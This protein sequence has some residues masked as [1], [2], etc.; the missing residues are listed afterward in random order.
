MFQEDQEGAGNEP[1]TH[2]GPPPL[3]VGRSQDSACVPM[4]GGQAWGGGHSGD[5]VAWTPQLILPV[6]G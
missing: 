1:A 6:G 5:A 4:G 3:Q 2:Q